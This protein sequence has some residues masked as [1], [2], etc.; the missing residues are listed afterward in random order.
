MQTHIHIPLEAWPYDSHQ[1]RVKWE[2][3]HGKRELYLH[4][5]ISIGTIQH[6]QVRKNVTGWV[7]SVNRHGPGVYVVIRWSC[8]YVGCVGRES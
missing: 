6:R 8:V 7:E 4:M 5:M 3:I 1:G 2:Q